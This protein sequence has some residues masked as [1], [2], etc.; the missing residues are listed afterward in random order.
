MNFEWHNV[1]FNLA[2]ALAIF[3]LI[4]IYTYYTD[5]GLSVGSVINGWNLRFDYVLNIFFLPLI[6]FFIAVGLFA[7]HRKVVISSLWTISIYFFILRILAI[8]CAG[9]A[10]LVKFRH[11]LISGS[12]MVLTSYITVKLI[13][14]SGRMIIPSK[15]NLA[16]LL[17][18]TAIALL[19]YF[20]R[21]FLPT[22]LDNFESNKRY[23]LKL[24]DKYSKKYQSVLNKKLKADPELK[25]LFFAILITEDQNRPIVFRLLERL[26]FR[27]GFIT[28]TGIMQ[29]SSSQKL[30]DLKSIQLAQEIIEGAY[31]LHRKKE[32]SEYMLVR[33]VAFEYNDGDFYR[34][35]I[36]NTYYILKEHDQL[37]A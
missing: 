6:S 17:W 3:G 16:L 2:A 5:H 26:F 8:L 23:V 36:I 33:A 9:R 21:E 29:V 34:E 18:F 10:Y 4:T 20:L 11:I 19:F 15:Q 1:L 27:Y 24:Y 35:L 22:G 13:V 12:L 25:R 31:N 30:S 37:K 7:L 32:K 14:L 28:T